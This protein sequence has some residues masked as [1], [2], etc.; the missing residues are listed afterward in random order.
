MSLF[1]QV[2]EL[3]QVPAGSKVINAD[4]LAGFYEIAV[5]TW[6]PQTDVWALKYGPYML[7]LAGSMSAWYGSIY[8]RKKLRLRNYGF[9]TMYLSNM[10]LP[11]LIVNAMQFAV[12]LI[13]SSTLA[14]INN[15]SDKSFLFLISVHPKRYFYPT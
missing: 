3:S 14:K 6:K 1:G 7:G 9:A 12:G 2:R 11:F 4:K 8:F 5:R 15:E 10:V 13:K